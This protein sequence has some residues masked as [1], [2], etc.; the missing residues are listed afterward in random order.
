MI[1]TDTKQRLIVND[2][3]IPDDAI[4]IKLN[5]KK[6]N[7]KDENRLMREEKVAHVGMIN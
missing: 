4:F 5:A 2:M 7:S 1:S 3:L 6:E